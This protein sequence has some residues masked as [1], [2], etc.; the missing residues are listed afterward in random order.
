MS[1]TYGP[2]DIPRLIADRRQARK[3][4]RAGYFALG[5]L[6]IGIA[7]IAGVGWYVGDSVYRS[8]SYSSYHQTALQFRRDPTFISVYLNFDADGPI[9]A[10]QPLNLRSVQMLG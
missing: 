4:R 2:E 7:G 6:V 5:V 9:T 1:G 8:M 3:R 10:E